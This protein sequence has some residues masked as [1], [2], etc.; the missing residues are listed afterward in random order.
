MGVTFSTIDPKDFSIEG[1]IKSPTRRISK[2]QRN[3][4][5]EQWLL[6]KH[7]KSLGYLFTC[8][9]GN[10]NCT[11]TLDYIYESELSEEHAKF[12][13][14]WGYFYR[15]KLW[16]CFDCSEI[17]RVRN[18]YAYDRKKYK[19]AKADYMNLYYPKESHDNDLG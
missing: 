6:E 5:K 18:I 16:L 13:A 1:N 7:E 15:I 9:C 19:K 8:E 14:E 11:E 12:D 10:K 4:L 3:I 2:K 17:Q